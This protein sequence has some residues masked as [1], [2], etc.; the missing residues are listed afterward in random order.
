MVA[1]LLAGGRWPVASCWWLF[2]LYSLL[3]PLNSLLSTACCWLAP[4]W[5]RQPARLVG[6][7]QWRV[8]CTCRSFVRLGCAL[9]TSQ[10]PEDSSPRIAVST[11]HWAAR[12][13][14]WMAQVWRPR[15]P[16]D[17]IGS[18]LGAIWA[19]PL[20]P[21]LES[22]PLGPLFSPVALA[23]QSNEAPPAR[24]IWAPKRRPPQVSERNFK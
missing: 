5:A 12:T 9:A 18:C 1:W 10:W 7:G 8:R 24:Q 2:P 14:K 21:Q 20:G 22:H 17:V 11:L 3:F 23:P 19:P 13:A 4:K 15:R 6:P 16:L